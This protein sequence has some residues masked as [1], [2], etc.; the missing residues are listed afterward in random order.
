MSNAKTRVVCVDD[1]IGIASVIKLILENNGYDVTTASDG[2]TGL[3][4]IQRLKPDLVLLD[5]S[6]P[7]IDGWEVYQQM[8]A[9]DELGR[10]PVIVI[11]ARSK[12]LD[13]II[14]LH[15]AKVD[16][17]ITKPFKPQDLLRCVS[18]VLDARA[19]GVPGG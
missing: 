15:V 16:G 3:E 18:Q 12:D 5:L 14:G 11:T 2:K 7:D 9:N 1:E 8:K 13:K 17:Y 19:P 10:I 4:A 6:M